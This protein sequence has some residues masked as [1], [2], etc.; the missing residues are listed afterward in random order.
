MEF[1]ISKVEEL[2]PNIDQD[3]KISLA[4][5]LYLIETGARPAGILYEFFEFDENRYISENIRIVK[6]RWEKEYPV[7]P[8]VV[9]VNTIIPESLLIPKKWESIDHQEIA[10]LLGYRGSYFFSSYSTNCR[11]VK[12]N[13]EH[14]GKD[15]EIFGYWFDDLELGI[16]TKIFQQFEDF[17]KVLGKK[18]V[19]IKFSL[20]LF[21]EW[22]T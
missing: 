11:S 17:K 21:L 20:P 3:E 15:Y 7:V 16:R 2:F 13:Y 6:I 22:S 9:N 1:F 4:A 19:N 8:A 18:K 12:F 10:K 14:E 5:N